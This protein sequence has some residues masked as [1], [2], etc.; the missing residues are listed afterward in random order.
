MKGKYIVSGNGYR[1]EIDWELDD[2]RFSAM[3]Y[4]KENGREY[5]AGQNLDEIKDLFPEDEM[6]SR[7]YKV[8]KKWHL[9]DMHAG[10]PDQEA[11]LAKLDYEGSDHYSWAKETLEEAGLNPDPNY[12]HNGEPY[13]YGSAWLK[14]DLPAEVI[15]EVMS[16]PSGEE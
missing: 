12:M 10:S 14:V 11:Y 13:S 7:I 5:S 3:G 16:W 4:L 1:A 8:W 9:N 6:V 15:D 2:G